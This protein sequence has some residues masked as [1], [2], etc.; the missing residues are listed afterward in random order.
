[1]KTLFYLKA[2]LFC[3]ILVLFLSGCIKDISKVDT[4]S[5]EN[6]QAKSG[7][8][9]SYN[10]DW[11]SATYMPSLQVNAVPMPWNS[12][13][14]AID[15]TI[16]SDF[17][18]DDGWRMVWNTFSPTTDI[19]NSQ[20]TLFFSL[21]NA[22]RGLLRFYLWQKP[23]AIA[24]D[25]VNHGLS[26]YGTT[27]TSSPILNFVAKDV[28]N[29][30]AAPQTTFSQIYKQP[31]NLNGGTWY[32]FQY[33]LAYDPAIANTS[34]PDFGLTWAS[35]YASVGQVNING[36][37]NGTITGT[38]G[39][40]PQ[41]STVDFNKLMADGVVTALGSANYLTLQSQYKDAI[42]SGLQN[43]V[44]NFLS[45]IL[46]MEGQAVSLNINASIQ[47]NGSIVT[48]GGL[49]N[50]KY[51]LPGQ[52]NSQTADGLTPVYNDVFGVFNVIGT[53]QVQ[54]SR[55]Y[56][57]Q[58]TTDPLDGSICNISGYNVTCWL[59]ANPVNI[60]WNPS[61]INNSSTGATIQNLNYDLVL[62]WNDGYLG[63][64]KIGNIN[65]STYRNP[66]QA[67]PVYTS[68]ATE[69]CP[70]SG[71]NTYVPPL[72]IRVSFDVVPNNGAK[73][74]RIVKTIWSNQL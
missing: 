32:V 27:N 46:G 73:K 20:V 48:N 2:F 31:I 54:I 69:V 40:Q 29:M 35:T 9:P 22:Y 60:S 57:T 7:P 28:L 10:F 12:G 52:L 19:N 67:N 58:Q 61:V 37:L 38:I 4:V 18:K 74:T 63:N 16:V 14:T 66:T 70:N 56:Y 25:Y 41:S 51:A 55:E 30:D 11:E 64:E 45:G 21:Y 33:E 44:K 49:E 13:T 68:Y 26:L 71:G 62:F 24:T 72:A 6:K 36:S 8:I 1:M 43:I 65:A 23:T 34:F 17:K 50:N 39:A 3:C 5:V 59:N 53:P 15:P 47:L 42:N